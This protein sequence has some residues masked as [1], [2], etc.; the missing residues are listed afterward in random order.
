[1][2]KAVE[3]V[4]PREARFIGRRVDNALGK[5]AALGKQLADGV[6]AAPPPWPAALRQP[7]QVAA[8]SRHRPQQQQ[9]E[10]LQ[11]PQEAASRQR[12]QQQECRSARCHIIQYAFSTPHQGTAHTPRDATRT[13]FTARTPEPQG[14]LVSQISAS[15]L[16]VY[17]SP[18][19]AAP[20]RMRARCLRQPICTRMARASAVVAALAVLAVLALLS[21]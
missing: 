11:R 15:A 12:P 4:G 7:P 6:A 1:M 19:V 14:A 20:A 5:K 9:E 2:A 21:K 16:R 3:A 18:R 8:E 10:A 13:R 17:A